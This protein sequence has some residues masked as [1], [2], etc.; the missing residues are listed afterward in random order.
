MLSRSWVI[1][2]RL[3]FTALLV[4]VAGQTLQ[5][6]HT[7]AAGET[8]TLTPN[9]GAVGSTFTITG[10]GFTT[11][12]VTVYF[13]G[14]LLGTA[15]VS[16]G[17]L[18]NATFHVPNVAA[19]QAYNVVVYTASGAATGFSQ[20]ATFTVVGAGSSLGNL[21]LTEYI[22]TASGF[23][24]CPANG[25]CTVQN[26]AGA[27]ETYA[28]QYQNTANA[29][30]T[31]LTVIDTLQAGQ[32]FVSASS[33]CVA[34]APAA[35]TGLVTVSCTVSNVPASP[36]NGST[37]SFIVTTSPSTGFAGV[38]TNAACATEAGFV[39]QACSNTTYL[40]VGGAS[41]GTG[42]QICGLITAYTPPSLFSNA[43]GFI[44]IGGQSFTIAPN[45]QING[46]IST[47]APNNNVCITFA[48][49]N[50]AATVLTVSSN[51]ASVN[52]VCGVLTAFS[53]STATITVGG[54]TYS[55]VSTVMSSNAFLYGQTYCFLIQNNTI[56]GVLTGTPTSVHVS[57][58][59][60][61]SRSQMIAE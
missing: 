47:A 36:L 18:V 19:N 54:I 7:Y 58:G 43:Y 41:V 45:A 30:I 28:L 50:Q 9:S 3:L 33:G 29:P 20:G 55:A 25:G 1:S 27:T 61:N 42:T 11:S 15:T 32:V 35:T 40:T 38:I 8:I 23:S 21:G 4:V 31:Q 6:T 39:G 26:Q 22:Q 2:I 53:P 57:L 12:S 51:L 48:F 24:S 16:S 34:G 37:N 17:S 52:V 60:G 46:S 5:P 56:V 44:T 10:S 14:G 13:N 59:A 49:A